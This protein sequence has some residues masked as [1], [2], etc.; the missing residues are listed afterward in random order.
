[1]VF[2]QVGAALALKQVLQQSSLEVVKATSGS[3]E[4]DSWREDTLLGLK[5]HCPRNEV[6]FTMSLLQILTNINKT[7][8]INVRQYQMMHFQTITIA[9]TL[10]IRGERGFAIHW[11][12][13]LMWRST[14]VRTLLLSNTK[15]SNSMG[16]IIIIHMKKNHSLK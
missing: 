14:T 5:H 1:M 16:I 8:S 11:K 7:H 4:Q 10:S 2:L 15:L 9:Q 6:I 3:A 12:V 13:N